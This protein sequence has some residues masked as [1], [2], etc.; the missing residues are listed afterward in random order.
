LRREIGAA[1]QAASGV[2]LWRAPET[3]DKAAEMKVSFYPAPQRMG[4]G[5]TVGEVDQG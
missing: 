2:S 1:R 3:L 4:L 5:K